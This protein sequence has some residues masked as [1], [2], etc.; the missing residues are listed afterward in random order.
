MVGKLA[1]LF[2]LN[3]RVALLGRWRYGSFAYIPVGAT[4]V[5]SIRVNFDSV[6][7]A[8]RVPSWFRS[9][10]TYDLPSKQSLRTNSPLRPVVPGTFS[11][12]TYSKASTMLGGQP[13]RAGDEIGGFWLGSTIVLVFEAPEFH[14]NIHNGQKLKV[15]EALGHIAA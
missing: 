5:G 15:G 9:L 4:N 2:V 7:I 8:F 12:A 6:R 13:L 10:T 14:F 1:D 11:E 3:E